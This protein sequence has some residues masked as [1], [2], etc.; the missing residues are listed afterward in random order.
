MSGIRTVILRKAKDS[1][2]LFSPSRN[3]AEGKPMQQHPPRQRLVQTPLAVP[4]LG[5]MVNHEIPVAT[6][7]YLSIRDPDDV[8]G[9][10]EPAF[11]NSISQIPKATPFRDANDSVLCGTKGHRISKS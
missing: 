11:G 9:R 3:N 7:S 10:S 5:D 2:L 6:F 1:R 4:T 8:D